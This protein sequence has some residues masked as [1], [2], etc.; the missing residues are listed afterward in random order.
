MNQ[1]MIK[2]CLN[3]FLRQGNVVGKLPYLIYQGEKI[4]MTAP[5]SIQGAGKDRLVVL[6]NLMLA[7][8][9]T[10]TFLTNTQEPEE[11]CRFSERK[12]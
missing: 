1:L 12:I 8:C 6:L 4:A 10:D 11:Q 3:V 2:R 9:F 5:V 7:V